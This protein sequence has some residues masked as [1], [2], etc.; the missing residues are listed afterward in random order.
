MQFLL[1]EIRFDDEVGSVRR[2]PKNAESSFSGSRGSLRALHVQCGVSL[3][4]YFLPVIY[5]Y[6]L[7][8]SHF[9]PYRGIL[10]PVKALS[11]PRGTA[12]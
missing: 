10:Q 7:P 1:T 6:F 12:T 3:P 9:S 4:T 2:V 11:A 8:S 5:G